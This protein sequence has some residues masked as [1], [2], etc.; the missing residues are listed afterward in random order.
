MKQEVPQQRRSRT[1]NPR[2]SWRGARQDS[3]LNDSAC[4]VALLER[5]RRV[6]SAAGEDHRGADLRRTQGTQ[7]T[8]SGGLDTLSS[9]YGEGNRRADARRAG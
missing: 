7:G 2:H 1:G 3:H 4:G 5:S 8:R 9:A 6:L